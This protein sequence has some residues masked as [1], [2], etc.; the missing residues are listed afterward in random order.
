MT[1][2]F[3]KLAA[4]A[5]SLFTLVKFWNILWETDNYT[6]L[7]WSDFIILMGCFL[8]IGT[9]LIYFTEEYPRFKL[10]VYY[11]NAS[12]FTLAIG[13]LCFRI[14]LFTISKICLLITSF[15]F[16]CTFLALGIAVIKTIFGIVN[17]M[18]SKPKNM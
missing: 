1:T 11:F 16:A 10:C 13:L 14:N 15:L 7:N 17:K 6:T 9:L 5:M 18:F 2:K 3:C 12:F 8:S 4:N